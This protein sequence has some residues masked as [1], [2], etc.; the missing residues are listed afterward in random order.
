MN[1]TST[2][3]FNGELWPWLSVLF[4]LT[5]ATYAHQTYQRGAVDRYLS[6]KSYSD[7]LSFLPQK[8]GSNTPFLITR[9]S[10]HIIVRVTPRTEEEF[11]RLQQASRRA[12]RSPVERIIVEWQ[13]AHQ[14]L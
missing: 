12:G 4:L 11:D 8:N 2:R 5:V 6:G 9:E 14:E 10:D 7:L 1:G 13:G 3:R